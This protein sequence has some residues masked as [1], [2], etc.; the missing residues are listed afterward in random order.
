MDNVKVDLET[1]AGGLLMQFSTLQIQG[2][3]M[4]ATATAIAMRTLAWACG[5]TDPNMT[6]QEVLTFMIDL[7]GHPEAF[8][9]RKINP[10]DC[11]PENLKQAQ[12]EFQRTGDTSIG[13]Y[14]AG[15][16]NEDNEKDADPWKNI[17]KYVEEQ[18]QKAFEE[19]QRGEV[20]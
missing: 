9:L 8:Q 17:N 2:D 19:A 14:V 11:T 1:L 20:H 4:G 15:R 10:K 3:E 13:K 7:S 5:H 16:T 6:A 12:E 18:V